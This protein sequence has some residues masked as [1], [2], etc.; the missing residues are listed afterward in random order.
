MNFKRLM[1]TLHSKK[2][3]FERL[4]KILF[5]NFNIIPIDSFV[6][7]HRTEMENSNVKLS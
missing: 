1:E 4:R 5:S 2:T 6:V 3:S 7:R